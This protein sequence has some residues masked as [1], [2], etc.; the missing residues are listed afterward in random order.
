M[1]NTVIRP[2]VT[3]AIITLE[4]RRR[5]IPL[6]DVLSR[7]HFIANAE[8]FTLTSTLGLTNGSRD[9]PLHPSEPRR[10]AEECELR[11]RGAARHD[12]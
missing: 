5:G 4:T 12:Q 3:I 11:E 9:T 10:K 6:N 8:A 2:T 1:Y 7:A